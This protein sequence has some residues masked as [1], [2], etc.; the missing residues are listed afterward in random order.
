MIIIEI[1]Q[2]DSHMLFSGIII[3]LICSFIKLLLIN[4]YAKKIF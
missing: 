2:D 1:N 4:V 3:A